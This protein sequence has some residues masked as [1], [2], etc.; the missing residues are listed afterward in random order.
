LGFA[1]R[2]RWSQ[3]SNA[4]QYYHPDQ[5]QPGCLTSPPA[6]IGLAGPSSQK[7]L[8]ENAAS[9][10]IFMK[11]ISDGAVEVRQMAKTMLIQQPKGKVPRSFDR[12]IK[13][14]RRWWLSVL[15]YMDYTKS[16]FESDLQ[17][18]IWLGGFCKGK[19]LI[20]H[21][22]RWECFLRLGTKDN[23]QNFVVALIK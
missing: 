19:A 4:K 17:K 2:L 18:I 1:I 23:W 3:N 21:Q 6:Y 15:Q 12:N 16:D 9:Y 14:F 22:T 20:S 8:A 7:K 5:L 11:W 13:E 10:K